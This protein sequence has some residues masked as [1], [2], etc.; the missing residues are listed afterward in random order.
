M[1]TVDWTG[2]CMKRCVGGQ[3][4]RCF[5]WGNNRYVDRGMDECTGRWIHIRIDRDVNEWDG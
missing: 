3:M 1:S 5:Y 4:D 2:G